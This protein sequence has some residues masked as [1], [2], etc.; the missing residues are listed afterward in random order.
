M[1]TEQSEIV[2]PLATYQEFLPSLVQLDFFVFKV[3]FV[4]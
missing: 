1:S 4:R 3:R 2:D